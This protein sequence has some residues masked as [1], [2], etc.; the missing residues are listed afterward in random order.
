[1]VQLLIRKLVGS[2]KISSKIR[3]NIFCKNSPLNHPTNH[4]PSKKQT[5]VFHK[6]V[7]N[8]MQ[9]VCLSACQ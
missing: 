3:P 5:N 1:M 8:I 9:S 2:S 7:E 6:H 4:K